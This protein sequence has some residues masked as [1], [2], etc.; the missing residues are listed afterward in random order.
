M[1]V[2]NLIKWMYVRRH[3]VEP[4]DDDYMYSTTMKEF[5][6]IG[7]NHVHLIIRNDGETYT[8]MNSFGIFHAHVNDSLPLYPFSDGRK[9]IPHLRC[10]RARYRDRRPRL[11]RMTP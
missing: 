6:P 10:G 2:G 9:I 3:V 8:W 4:V 1:N 7:T 11:A 5:V